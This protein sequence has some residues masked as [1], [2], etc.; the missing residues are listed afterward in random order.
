MR[1]SPGVLILRDDAGPAIGH[2]HAMRC[3]A[4]AQAWQDAG[5]EAVFAMAQ[6]PSPFTERL[7]AEDISL[8]CI[9]AVPGS[10]EDAAQLR[11][12]AEERGAAWVVVDG[13][14]FSASYQRAIKDAALKL[15]LIDDHGGGPY[16]ADLV[17]NQNLQASEGMY[18]QRGPNTRLLLGT[19][20]ALL[21]REFAKWR[22]WKREIS[23]IARKLLVT[24]GGSDPENFTARVLQVLAP[25]PMKELEAAVVIG[26][27]NPHTEDLERAGAQ[28]ASVRLHRNVAD[29]GS[30]MA[31][32]DMG[33]SAAGATCWELCL[34]G[35]PALLIDLAPNQR[36]LAEELHRRGAAIHLGSLHDTSVEKLAQELEET[37]R[38]PET[39]GRMS[40]RA[41]SLVDGRGA[42]RVVRGMLGSGLQVRRAEEKDC[43]LLW[44]WANDPEVRAAS[45]TSEPIPWEA[46]QEWFS[47]KLA[48]PGC[49]LYVISDA[50]WGP[51]GQVRYDLRRNRALVSL[52]L[53]REFRGRGYGCLV[54]D[55]TLEELRRTTAVAAVDA[56]VKPENQASLRLFEQAGFRR[57]ATELHSG[58]AAVH[59]VAESNSRGD[60]L[61]QTD[62]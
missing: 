6:P 1:Y 16:F 62:I 40:A 49:I 25:G 32:A 47:A 4:L 5:G 45:F 44:E 37:A 19:R 53:G 57:Q 2:G 28:A 46:H 39:R 22:E 14:H 36:P 7:Q 15:L 60:G 24:M 58:Q 21:R 13:Y 31:W 27:S 9:K 26:G 20:Y 11:E 23:P 34:L 52:S 33:I 43:R 3:L 59:F 50:Q 29:M 54:L 48:D 61:E 8:V 42:E 35:L 41:R 30:L 55:Q 17:L 10:P 38:S 56:F 18:E 51:I 12:L